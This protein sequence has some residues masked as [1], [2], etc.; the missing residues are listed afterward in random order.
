MMLLRTNATEANDVKI[1]CV[2]NFFLCSIQYET[3][4]WRLHIV[5][6]LDAWNGFRFDHQHDCRSI[7]NGTLMDWLRSDSSIATI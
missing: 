2:L 3:R 7:R 5:E 4:S 1:I 6:H